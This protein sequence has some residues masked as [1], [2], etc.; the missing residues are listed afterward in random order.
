MYFIFTQDCNFIFKDIK[1]VQSPFQ[2]SIDRTTTP[3]MPW[4]DVAGCVI[5]AA[6]RDMARHFIQR[7]NYVKTKKVRNN[8]K[9]PFLLPKTYKEYSISRFNT[10]SYSCCNVQVLRSVANWSAGISKTES[11]I[12][13]AMKHLIKTSKHYIYIE[14][15]FFISN[16]DDNSVVKNEIAQCIYERI[17]QAWVKKEN[18]KV[19]IF[20]PLIPGYEGQ[21]G[22]PSGVLLHAITH[23]NNA[24]INGLIRKLT[25]SLIDS[26]NYLC[27]FG[28]RTWGELNNR[29][30][31]ELIYVHSKLLIVD[32]EAC[33]IGSANINDRSLLGNRDSEISLFIRDTQYVNGVMNKNPCQVGKFSS[34]LRKRLFREFLGEFPTTNNTQTITLDISDPC[35]DEFYKQILLKYAKQNTKIYDKVFRVIPCDHVQNFEQLK[36]YQKQKCLNQQNPSE[37]KIELSKTKGYIVLYPKKFLCFEKLTPSI[38]TKENLLPTSL[39]T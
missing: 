22:K 19:Y 33:I 12:H 13:E 23:F 1:N 18:F 16:I 26:S 20:L 17:V 6:A 4:H 7:W 3:R 34:T 9:Y 36:E 38:G 30:V 10:N 5:G 29:L 27:F 11:S 8:K 32:D 15:Q 25:D 14:N 2:D 35:S 24:S 28:L 31:T 37:A 39:W 21:Y